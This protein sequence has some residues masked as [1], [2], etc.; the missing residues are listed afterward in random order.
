MTTDNVVP[1]MFEHCTAVYRAMANEAQTI[2][3]HLVW[4]GFLTT[5]I[6]DKLN[7]ATPYYT[8]IRKE[9]TRMACIRQL[10]RGGSTT[11]SQW[12]LLGEPTVDLY[13][14]SPQR[15]S[16]K[17][18]ILGSIDQRVVDL[19]RRV[20]TLERLLREGITIAREAS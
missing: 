7:F 4:E 20:D 19:T 5:L 3:G 13:M 9:L 2:D 12:E 14:H 15:R 18:T 8:S 1:V 16:D 10:R 6:N 11:P 17:Q